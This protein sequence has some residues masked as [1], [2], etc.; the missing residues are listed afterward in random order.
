MYENRRLRVFALYPL[1]CVA[2]VQRGGRRK[3]KFEREVRG[4]HPKV[5]VAIE[6]A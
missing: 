2:G 6:V 1:A 4:E 5:K 3:V